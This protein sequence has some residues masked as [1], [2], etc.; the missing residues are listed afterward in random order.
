MIGSAQVLDIRSLSGTAWG[1]SFDGS[2]REFIATELLPDLQVWVSRVEAE[3]DLRAELI[4][5]GVI[6]PLES[7]R[8][9]APVD[10]ASLI[11]ASGG[12][13]DAHLREM[14]Q[15]QAQSP[16]GFIKSSSAITGPYDII[17]LPSNAP[18]MVDWEAEFACV[19]GR[20]CHQVS[21]EEA[22]DYVLGYTLVNDVSARDWV[23]KFLEATGS[24]MEVIRQAELNFM[25]KQYPTFCP[26]GPC[27]V[28]KDEIPDPHRLKLT[29][30]VNGQIKQSAN[31]IDLIFPLART[32]SY[33]SQW[34]QF[35]P[36]DV[37][38]TGSPAGVG[39]MQK[40]QQFLRAGDVV[41]VSIEEIG[42]LR[43]LVA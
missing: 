23:A 3:P 43:N 36:G 13:Y 33:F 1:N 16:S 27:I 8:I 41:E 11:V 32:I 26:I 14:A 28:T 31:T 15:Q 7:V 9:G 18:S 42:V 6:L 25:G 2:L 37:I 39:Y 21:E 22:I 40:P 10:R 30:R 20:T 12:G 17:V 35:E 19:I 24:P 5:A 29:T 34:Y 4:R 38:T